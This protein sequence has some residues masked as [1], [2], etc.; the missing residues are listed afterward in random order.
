MFKY[1]STQKN[2]ELPWMDDRNVAECYRQPLLF[3]ASNLGEEPQETDPDVGIE[4]PNPESIDWRVKGCVTPV[5][6]QGTELPACWIFSAVSV[7]NKCLTS[8]TTVI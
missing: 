7:R 1:I 4:G 5:Q 6:D 2:D 3:G 8:I